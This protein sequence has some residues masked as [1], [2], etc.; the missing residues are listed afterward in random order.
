MLLGVAVLMFIL[1]SAVA[2]M[3][4]VNP[5]EYSVAAWKEIV[6]SI[7]GGLMVWLGGGPGGSDA[8]K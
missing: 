1:L 3:T 4:G 7:V 6:L 5:Q 8:H 2:R